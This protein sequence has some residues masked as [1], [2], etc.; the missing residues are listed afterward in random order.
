MGRLPNFEQNNYF[1]E[2]QTRRNGPVQCFVG[3]PPVSRTKILRNSVLS[4]VD[5][6]FPFV[7]D[8]MVAS[9]T[10]EQHVAEVRAV[11]ERLRVVLNSKKCIFGVDGVDFLGHIG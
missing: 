3:D 11:L 8:V 9:I 4:G 2:D 6:A 7:D 5:A 1:E 10:M